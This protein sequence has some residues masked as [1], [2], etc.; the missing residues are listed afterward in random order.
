MVIF[1][2]RVVIHKKVEKFRGKS[3]HVLVYY[4]LLRTHGHDLYTPTDWVT[5][6]V[7]TDDWLGG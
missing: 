3:L 5:L 1:V 2:V 6:W 4:G 7:V